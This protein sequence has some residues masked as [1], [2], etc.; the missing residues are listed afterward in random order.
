LIYSP[1]TEQVRRFLV[2]PGTEYRSLLEPYTFAAAVSGALMGAAI[3]VA[4]AFIL[5]HHARRVVWWIAANVLGWAALQ[6]VI[7]AVLSHDLLVGNR[8]FQ[9]AGIFCGLLAL[10]SVTGSTLIE[11]LRKQVIYLVEAREQKATSL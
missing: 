3:G 10:G 4:Q 11:L 9:I 7:M 5:R 1:I 8:V 2:G 6:A